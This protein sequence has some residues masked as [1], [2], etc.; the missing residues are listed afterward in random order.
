LW[1]P[2]ELPREVVVAEAKTERIVDQA[3]AAV[4]RAGRVLREIR[5]LERAQH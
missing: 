4:D 5:R 2:R 3:K 1:K